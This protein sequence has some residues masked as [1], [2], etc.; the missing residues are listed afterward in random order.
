MLSLL[1][2]VLFHWLENMLR[3]ELRHPSINQLNSH[4]LKL[5]FGYHQNQNI[6]HSLTFRQ[7]RT[8]LLT[9]KVGMN[10]LWFFVENSCRILNANKP[11]FKNYT[12]ISLLLP[13]RFAYCLLLFFLTNTHL[14]L[15]ACRRKISVRNKFSI[16]EITLASL[17]P[18]CKLYTAHVICY[19][20]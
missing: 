17:N 4:V 10:K 14:Y 19:S 15:T 8:L 13:P 12:F 20:E 6:Y 3:F 16:F 5:L 9:R 11:M 7:N 2:M 1:Y 18:W